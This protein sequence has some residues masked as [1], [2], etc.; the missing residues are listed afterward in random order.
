MTIQISLSFWQL[1]TIVGV[2]GS[3]I[4]IS[5]FFAMIRQDT[6][7]KIVLFG[8]IAAGIVAIVSG[9]YAY[10][11]WAAFPLLVSIFFG[12]IPISF[13]IVPIFSALFGLLMIFSELLRNKSWADIR[14]EIESG[15]NKNEH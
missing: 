8:M 6:L 1:F 15:G 3:F 13:F 2:A 10:Y 4:G 12:M 14:G 7:S 11:F 9:L 5:I